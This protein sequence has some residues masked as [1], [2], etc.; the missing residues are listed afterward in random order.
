MRMEGNKNDMQ[1]YCVRIGDYVTGRLEGSSIKDFGRM[2]LRCLSKAWVERLC[3][4]V[5]MNA[6]KGLSGILGYYVSREICSEIPKIARSY[7][8]FSEKRNEALKKLFGDFFEESV[9]TVMGFRR[10]RG[11]ESCPINENMIVPD[12][13]DM[14]AVNRA[15]LGSLMT[16]MHAAETH[17]NESL[18][19]E[20]LKSSIEGLAKFKKW[21]TRRDLTRVIIE[22]SCGDF[23]YEDKAIKI[24]KLKATLKEPGERVIVVGGFVPSDFAKEIHYDLDFQ[25][26]LKPN[27]KRDLMNLAEKH[28]LKLRLDTNSMTVD[29]DELNELRKFLSLS[30]SDESSNSSKCES[31][32]KIK[33]KVI[34]TRDNRILSER[35]ME[36]IKKEKIAETK[37]TALICLQKE[38]ENKWEKERCHSID[39]CRSCSNISS[40]KHSTYRPYDMAFKWKH[41]VEQQIC[42]GKII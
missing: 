7:R 23:D 33:W 9:D 16:L 42:E 36:C 19:A 41:R 12:P 15:N 17:K 30:I 22:Q 25:F 18:L 20:I 28:G 24:G 8:N 13:W 37:K 5:V 39:G 34:R 4:Y 6:F 21:K 3:Y 35:E 29:E 1:R 11:I 14:E 27:E 2:V 10:F 32:W 40:P 31:K 38:Q 26:G